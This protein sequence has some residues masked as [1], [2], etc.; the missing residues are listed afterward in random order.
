M[1]DVLGGAQQVGTGETELDR[2]S[3]LAVSRAL[4]S[5]RRDA[6]IVLGDRR[7]DWLGEPVAPERAGDP[8]RHL[9]DLQFRSG[10]GAAPTL[11]RKA[12]YVEVGP[13]QPLPDGCEV[14]IR[15][16][17]A[18]LAPLFPVFAGSLRWSGN[19]LEL[20]GW[21]QPPG[22]GVGIIADRVL[23]NR[24]AQGTGEWLLERVAAAIN[25][26]ARP[27]DAS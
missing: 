11:L 20:D 23:L 21:Y 25:G 16:R 2:P 26:R 10:A 13:L 19:R 5:R 27:P 12:A 7:F 14:E 1:D 17:A 22:G 24:I 8:P 4:D 6:C 15:W 18:T 9:L 3:R